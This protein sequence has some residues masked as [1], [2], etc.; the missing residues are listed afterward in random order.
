MQWTRES[1]TPWVSSAKAAAMIVKLAIDQIK[2]LI[3]PFTPPNI[4]TAEGTEGIAADMGTVFTG[5]LESLKKAEDDLR[6]AKAEADKRNMTDA[7]G[8]RIFNDAYFKRLNEGA[9]IKQTTDAAKEFWAKQA[10]PEGRRE[11]HDT[12]N[13]NAIT[14]MQENNSRFWEGK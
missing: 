4:L 10:T 13:Q 5:A 11:I 7:N 8:V 2:D 6:A 1:A 3:T 12:K 9:L 14:T